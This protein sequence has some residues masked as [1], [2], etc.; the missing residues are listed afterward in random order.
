MKKILLALLILET[1]AIAFARLNLL[2]NQGRTSATQ[3]RAECARLTS[4][5][6]EL[7]AT[8]NELRAQVQAKK[9]QFAEAPLPSVAGPDAASGL[10]GDPSKA[11]RRVTPAEL[12]QRFGIGWNNSA[13]YILVS[14]AGLKNMDLSAIESNGTFTAT[15]CAILA[16]TPMERA[17]VEAGLKRVEAEYA[18]W[19]KTAVQRVEPAGDV[20]ADYRLPANPELAHRIEEEGTALL[21]GTLGPDRAKL[22][23]YYADSWALQ[24]G[25]LGESSFRYTVRRHTDGT[26]PPLWQ[27]FEYGGAGGGAG[28][29]RSGDFPEPLRSLFPGG[30]RGLAQREGFALPEGFE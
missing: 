21:L 1:G 3:S 17:T 23:R 11:S 29:L 10:S 2:A 7:V 19:A 28:D 18:A 8:A 20:L 9:T 16:L 26:Q 22:V 14:K 6:N 4:R 12:R 15:A 13:D 30:W 5:V 27:Q 24:H 25:T